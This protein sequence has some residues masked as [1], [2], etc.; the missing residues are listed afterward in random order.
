MVDLI[1][2][3][4]SDKDSAWE[5]G[6]GNFPARFNPGPKILGICLINASEAK[7]ASYFLANFL[8]SFLFL[9]NFFKSSTDIPS[10]PILAASSRCCSSPNMQSFILG[11]GVFGS[12]IDP[13][14]RLS[15]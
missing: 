13:A 12:L 4:L 6:D 15:L 11:L 5:T 7:K 8:I 9:F 1:S 3:A 14:K 2:S 10:I